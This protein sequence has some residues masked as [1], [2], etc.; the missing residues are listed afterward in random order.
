MERIA[1]SWE[2]FRSAAAAA[3]D[4]EP[5]PASAS[6]ADPSSAASGAESRIVTVQLRFPDGS[7]KQRRFRFD[8]PVESLFL[9]LDSVFIPPASWCV[10]LSFLHF[11][12]FFY[13][14]LRLTRL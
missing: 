12:Q 9:F 6:A 11:K 8:A 3:L 13:M 5:E 1:Q 10:F 14:A 2:A 7:R 4:P